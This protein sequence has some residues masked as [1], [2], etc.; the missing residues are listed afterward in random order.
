MVE[1]RGA[2][3]T[4]LETTLASVRGAR[5]TQRDPGPPAA[6]RRPAR[7]ASR[8]TARHGPDGQAWHVPPAAEGSVGEPV[9]FATAKEQEYAAFA[10]GEAW[11]PAWG[12]TWFHLTG[13]V[14]ADLGA[15][16]GRR[17]PRLRPGQAGFQAEGLVHRPDGTAVKGL[18]PRNDW[19]PVDP[20]RA[21]RPVRRGGGQPACSTRRRP[22]RWATAHRRRR[23]RSTGCAAAD[24]SP[25][26]PE[27]WELVQDV[28]VLDQLAAE[29]AGD[30]ARAGGDPARAGARP[31][32]PRPRRRPGHRG[33]GPRARWRAALAAP[34]HGERPPDRPRS[35]TRTST[36]RGCGRCARPCARW[37]A[38]SSNVV[39]LMDDDPDLVFAM[40]SAQQ[41]AWMEEH[42]PELFERVEEKVAAGPVRAGRRHVGR[43]R[44]QHARRR[45]AGPPVRA[46]QAVLPRA[47]SASRPRR[48]GCPTR[49]ATRAALPQL[50]QLSGSRW[51]LTQKISWN[52]TNRFPHHTFWWE[53]IDGT[54]VFTHFPPVDTYNAELSGARAGPRA[55]A[56]S[57]TRARRPARWCRSGTATAAAARPARCWPGA[58]RARPGG[59]ARVAVETPRGVLRRRPRPST[60]DA[61]GLGRRAVPGAAPRHLHLAGRDQAGQ[62]AQR[63]P[64]ARGRAVGRHRRR[65]RPAAATRTRTL[66]RIWKTV[67]LHQFHDIL[68]GSSIAW[69][70]REARATYAGVAVSSRRSSPGPSG[71]SPGTGPTAASCS[72]RRRTPGAASPPAVHLAGPSRRRAPS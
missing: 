68:P 67:L 55:C 7:P 18:N 62:P 3:A 10:V 51:F 11:G 63:A 69:V 49:S 20:R 29:L 40:S 57:P 1:V 2:P 56:T 34:A 41:F 23:A 38:R 42:R 45:G 21:R 22:R 54:R 53:G 48:C 58:R 64:A 17:R 72:T 28:E 13:T 26:T 61:A 31:G 46:R 6:H 9:P 19:V 15:P 50:V 33:R 70:H 16:R 59:L 35:A 39:D 8:A 36:P 66:D 25:S 5:P 52:Q 43:V 14:P 32:R 37:R 71:R 12:T 47:S 60:A 27:V 44:H 4:S 24:L 30:D 65:P